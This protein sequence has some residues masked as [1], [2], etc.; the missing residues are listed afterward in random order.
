M[1]SKM[2][3]TNRD[4]DREVTKPRFQGNKD[5][6]ISKELN[7]K[8]MG[9]MST[10]PCKTVRSRAQSV[11]SW[12]GQFQLLQIT[13]IKN[14]RDLHMMKTSQLGCSIMEMSVEE[15]GRPPSTETLCRRLELPQHMPRLYLAL[16]GG[17]IVGS[18]KD[19]FP[20]RI[21]RGNLTQN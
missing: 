14:Q 6:N 13:R 9:V 19:V 10:N 17:G 21:S 7:K 12:N 18:H 3:S 2:S 4:M 15:E 5:T 11:T 20:N 1:C 16:G 8:N